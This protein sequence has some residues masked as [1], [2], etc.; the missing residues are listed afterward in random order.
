MNRRDGFIP[1]EPPDDAPE[2]SQAAR[3]RRDLER[4]LHDFTT[5][6]APAPARYSGASFTVTV[7]TLLSP[8][9]PALT[10]GDAVGQALYRMAEH[11]V[12]HLPVV[13]AG[14]HLVGLISETV[15]RAHPD[16]DTP[17][18]ALV[19]GESVFVTADTHVFDAAHRMLAH[20]LS[21]MPVAGA[22]GRYL[23]L[24]VR[25]ALFGQ[26]AHMLATEEPGAIVVLEG[27]RRDF[28][29]AQLAHLIEQNDVRILSV[30]SEDDP[31]AGLV[32]VT[33]KL[34]VTDTARVR[35]L[36]EHHG[37]RIVALFDEADTD[38][39]GRVD[40]FLRYLEV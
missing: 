11:G 6:R 12:E 40:A 32:R 25:P 38:L 8:T 30:S 13:G 28:S 22:D 4:L 37:Y 5:G 27:R 10:V 23:G 36:M 35:H 15:L 14:G 16:P 33:L 9:V 24:V 39:Q 20:G 31:G 26:L 3:E 17:L 29:L 7:Q 2:S 18:A 21:V 19:G 1:V 34:N